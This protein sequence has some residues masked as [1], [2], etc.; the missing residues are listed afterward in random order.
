MQMM[1]KKKIPREILE[2]F[3]KQGAKGGKI[4]GTLRAERMTPQ[5]RSEAARKAVLVRWA[6]TKTE[7]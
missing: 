5:E 4:G 6:K 3:R 2:F 1:A 7:A